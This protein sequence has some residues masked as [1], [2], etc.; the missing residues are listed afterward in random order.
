MQ[1]YGG[2]NLVPIAVPEI[3]WNVSLLNSRKL[4]LN[5][6]SAFLIKSSVGIVSKSLV[7]AF[8][9]GNKTGLMRNA[10]I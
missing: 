5:S 1:A 3:C 2:V 9:K 7:K 6:N 8:L 10:W 4:L